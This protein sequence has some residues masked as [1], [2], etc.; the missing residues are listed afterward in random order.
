MGKLDN[1]KESNIWTDTKCFINSY[2]EL[3][4][5]ALPSQT[6]VI[7]LGKLLNGMSV[8]GGKGIAQFC[9]YCRVGYFQ[10]NN[11]NDNNNNSNNN[12]NNNN[13]NNNNN[14]HF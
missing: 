5:I 2:E 10:N 6:G 8:K 4:A 12:D 1:I 3:L 9:S 7:D 13:N 14:Q 11:N